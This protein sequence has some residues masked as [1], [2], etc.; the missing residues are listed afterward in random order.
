[1]SGVAF[2]ISAVAEPLQVVSHAKAQDAKFLLQCITAEESLPLFSA[3]PYCAWFFEA[4][5]LWLIGLAAGWAGNLLL[6]F[7]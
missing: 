4:H 3:P 1:M 7:N 5:C 2:V 6:I